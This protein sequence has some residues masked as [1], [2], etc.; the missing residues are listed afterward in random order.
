MVRRKKLTITLSFALLLGVRAS[1]A[2]SVCSDLFQS[3]NENEA[4][5]TAWYKRH[6]KI[7]DAEKLGTYP[8]STANPVASP[9]DPAIRRWLKARVKDGRLRLDTPL[10]PEAP[11]DVVYNWMRWPANYEN[12]KLGVSEGNLRMFVDPSGKPKKVGN[13]G[14]YGGQDPWGSNQFGEAL[15]E[16]VL[17]KDLFPIKVGNRIR[18]KKIS[19]HQ[20]SKDPARG[21]GG[22]IQYFDEPPMSYVIRD[23]RVIKELRWPNREAVMGSW[24]HTTFADDWRNQAL[25]KVGA[26]WMFAENFSQAERLQVLISTLERVR[27][28]FKLAESAHWSHLA[29]VKTASTTPPQSVLIY[30]N[31]LRAVFKSKENFLTNENG[32]LSWKAMLESYKMLSA[33]DRRSVADFVRALKDDTHFSKMIRLVQAKG[34]EDHPLAHK[35]T[36][37][38]FD[39][40]RAMHREL[41]DYLSY[42][43]AILAE[44][45]K[46]LEAVFLR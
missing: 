28:Y 37:Q 42:D 1:F 27:K 43:P 45:K 4:W 31:L 32:R 2:Q 8:G 30:N 13:L 25:T 41:K 11:E 39:E 17:Y 40:Y 19:R 15:M 9:E 21:A 34:D 29:P 38:L 6:S 46:E 16:I 33:E 3:L 22:S 7:P 20:L 12:V 14:L 10:A 5:T 24:L 36:D 35:L 18:F 44:E 23:P 26:H